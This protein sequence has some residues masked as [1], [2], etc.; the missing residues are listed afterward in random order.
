MTPTPAEGYAVDICALEVDVNV[1]KDKLEDIQSRIKDY[2][3]AVEIAVLRR[4]IDSPCKELSSEKK[5]ALH[6]AEKL[7]EDE[8]YQ[9]MLKQ[10]RNLKYDIDLKRS[11]VDFNRR[12][13]QIRLAE[14]QRGIHGQ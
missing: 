9:D 10:E 11:E 8:H 6:V 3:S 2:T 14:L 7:R 13:Y 1:I 5:I 4:S 12:M